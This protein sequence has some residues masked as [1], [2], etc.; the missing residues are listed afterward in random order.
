MAV[1]LGLRTARPTNWRQRVRGGPSE[2]LALID[3]TLALLPGLS[4]LTHPHALSTELSGPPTSW[5]AGGR[6]W[7]S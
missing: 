4:A 1:A 3:S 7:A 2:E 6:L 5:G